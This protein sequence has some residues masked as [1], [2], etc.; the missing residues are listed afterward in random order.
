MLA[1]EELDGALARASDEPMPIDGPAG[2]TM[3]YTSGITGRPKGVKRARQPTLGDALS[4][5]GQAGAALGFDG[6]GPHLVTGPLYHAAPLL[7]AIYDQTNGAPVVVMPRW[8]DTHVLR[9]I[10]ERGIRHTHM[11][12]TMFV[13]LLRLPED[14]RSRVDLSSLRLVVHGAA[15]I[16]TV[17]QEVA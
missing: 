1:G 11:V 17:R 14:I 8:D 16:G 15:P 5:W 7:F 10:Q 12:P 6:S 2:G 9:L 4:A 13:R 3:I